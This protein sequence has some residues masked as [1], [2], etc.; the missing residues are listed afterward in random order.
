[1]GLRFILCVLYSILCLLGKAQLCNGS[2]GDPIININFGSGSNP[3]PALAAAATG[4]QYL[5]ADCPND[6]YYTVTTNTNNCF[7]S[8][9]HSLNSDHTQNGNGYFM[10]VNASLQ[11]SAF[12]A[13]TVRGLCG[14]SLYEFAAWVMNVLT[15]NAC[16]GAGIQPNLTFT[17]EQLNGTIL[18]SYS[19]GNIPATNSP[20]WKQFGFFF[21][22][23]A[24]VN[25]Y[26]LRIVNNAPG[27][28]GNDL[29]LDDITFR[30]CGPKLTPT[31]IGY[32]KDSI[33]LCQGD[34][35]N[36]IIDC[37]VSA[38][39]NMPEFK[40]QESYNQQPWQ[41]VP[42]NNTLQMPVQIFA[43]SPIGS[44]RYRL[45]AAEAGNIDAASCRIYSTP[46][47]IIVHAN[48]IAL[49]HNYGPV[50][51]GTPVSL[52]A[53]GGTSYEWT[54]PNGF[55]AQGDTIVIPA[56]M[57]GNY[58]V[59][60]SNDAGCHASTNTNVILLPTPNI[61]S[62]NNAYSICEMD[63]VLLL[64]NGGYRYKWIPASGLS[65]DSIASPFASPLQTIIYSAI[66]YNFQGCSDTVRISVTVFTK[67]IAHAG[68]DKA[69]MKGAT[70]N[71]EGSIQGDY[72][73]FYWTPSTG[74]SNI[75]SLTPTVL[76]FN[77][78]MYQ[79]IAV[80]KNNC[81]N[82][83]DAVAVKLYNDIY[84]PNIFTPDNNGINDTWNIPALQAF[85]QF[86][87]YVYDRYGK[88]VYTAHKQFIP[89][90]GTYKNTA[91]PVGAYTY[92][93]RLNNQA[94][95]IFKGSIL[96]MR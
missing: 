22:T 16:S 43:N 76:A 28:C 84:I 73:S 88:I 3:G 11:P 17:I 82:S 52:S 64:V 56:P 78:M 86:E 42:G 55:T 15:P 46:I 61:K 23:P 48:P 74:L 21:S 95:D 65:N 41:D 90:D 29:A 30:S 33:D 38:G 26:V 66:G 85:P 18:H 87:L 71:L 77:D 24:G 72:D 49:I 70:I 36:F 94:K 91:L 51:K 44:Y 37:T 69:V 67:A 60:V 32:T 45:I 58:M 4:Y 10:L 89:W 50:C 8:S 81:G 39:F 40:W 12:Y 25:D 5:A 75:H 6:G 31:I 13:D 9:W 83:L 59:T 68:P 47:E 27:G 19:S 20:E 53:S 1:M 62:A 93:I 92:L 63:S 2:L 57:P 54:G 79:L 96:L 35:E 14:N 7:G 34:T 80:S